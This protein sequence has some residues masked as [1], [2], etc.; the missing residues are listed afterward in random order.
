MSLTP[1]CVKCGREMYCAK[2]DVVVYHPFEESPWIEK[3][4]VKAQVITMEWEDG[5]I[6]FLV[7]GDKYKCRTCGVE[8]IVG[9][10]DLLMAIPGSRYKQEDLKRIVQNA[11]ES[12][13]ISRV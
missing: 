10:G 13:K 8:I 3:A 6:D 7:F 4:E 9:Y 2:N 5:D 11:E 1:I 12:V